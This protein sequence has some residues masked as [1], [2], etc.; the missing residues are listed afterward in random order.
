MA[1]EP[2]GTSAC[3]DPLTTY[4]PPAGRLPV[5]G[6]IRAE[7]DHIRA[8]IVNDRNRT[9]NEVLKIQAEIAALAVEQEKIAME[10]DRIAADILKI[11]AEVLALEVEKDKLTAEKDRIIQEGFKIQAEI[12][13]IATHSDN[14]TQQTIN[15]TTRATNDTNKT[16]GELQALADKTAAEVDL[17]NQKTQT[18]LANVADTVLSGTVTGL[19]GQQKALFA[20]QA[21]GFDRDAEQKL[22]KIMV[23]TWSVRMTAGDN[24]LAGTA[25]LGEEHIKAVLNAARTGINVAT[26]A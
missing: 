6:K 8:T 7:V 1:T 20:K 2:E 23:D 4:T 13:A 9:A 5:L 12:A 16:N 11:N 19:V 24:A 21:E 18:E 10:R 15:D 14:E 22:A 26:V 17:L 3:Y 25:S